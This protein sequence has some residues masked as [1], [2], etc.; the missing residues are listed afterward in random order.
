VAY[1]EKC[2]K[3]YRA[4]YL[5]P[6]GTYGSE[7]GFKNKTAAKKWGEAEEDKIARGVWT[8]PKAARTRFGDWVEKWWAAQDLSV[9][10]MANYETVLNNM[11]LPYLKDH[12]IGAIRP[13]DVAAWKKK[14]RQKYAT[15]SIATAHAR[16]HTIMADAVDNGVIPANPAVSKR[17][18]GQE[19]DHAETSEEDEVWTSPLGALLVA[20][21]CGILGGRDEDFLFPITKAYTGMRLGEM[22]GLEKRYCRAKLHQ[23]IRVEWQLVEVRGTFYRRPPKKNSRGD[24]PLPS[25]LAELLADQVAATEKNICSCPDAHDE[26][27]REYVFLGPRGGHHHRT[28]YYRRQWTPAVEGRRPVDKG[29]AKPVYVRVEGLPW[30][31]RPVVGRNNAARAEAAWLAIEPGLTPHGLRHSHKTWMIDDGIPEVASFE[32]LRHKLGGIRGVYSHVTPEMRQ[33]IL[34][35]LEERWQGALEQRAAIDISAGREPRSAVPLLD[36]LL[37][38][39]REGSVKAGGGPVVV[40]LREG[41]RAAAG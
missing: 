5:R 24:V 28:N 25:F 34:D 9:T 35:G 22:L 39:W 12:E 31:G 36:K 17:K 30:P 16:L 37:E 26:K 23:M 33:R 11:I 14:L 3:G 19:E 41:R 1:A 18:R 21:R 32:R 2:G 40:Q 4:R 8:D 15:A 10:S 29:D 38:P 13:I 27:P 6:D 7:P 20:E